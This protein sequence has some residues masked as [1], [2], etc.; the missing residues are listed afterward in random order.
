MFLVRAFALPLAL[1]SA[2]LCFQTA[3]AGELMPHKAEYA[4][5]LKSTKQ[6]SGV[7]GLKGSMSFSIA[8]SC[9]GWIIENKTVMVTQQPEGDEV[10]T[11]WNFLTWE[12]KNGLSYRFHVKSLRDGERAE[13]I[14]GKATLE[15]EG[16]SGKA[17]LSKPETK[18]IRL[19]K[20]TLFPV[21][22]TLT[23]LDQAAKGKTNFQRVVFDGSS[24]DSPQEVSALIGSPKPAPSKTGSGLAGN[25]L[26]SRPSWPSHMAFFNIGEKDGLPSYEISLRYFDNGIADDVLE[27]YGSFSVRSTL[28]KLEPLPRPDC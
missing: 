15:G 17:L 8:D 4:L 12:A 21:A 23:L 18:T 11:R 9:D 27:D 13:E 2:C 7:V 20:G 28:I 24:L 3:R 10:E 26:L 25:P 16:G 6:G 22:H 1:L 5:S 14:E 19:P